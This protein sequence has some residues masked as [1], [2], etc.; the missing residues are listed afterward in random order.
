VVVERVEGADE[1][2][3]REKPEGD[4]HELASSIAMNPS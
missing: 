2:L 3:D 1:T 4:C